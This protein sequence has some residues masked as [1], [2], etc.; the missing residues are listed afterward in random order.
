VDLLIY[1]NYQDHQGGQEKT[2]K[3]TIKLQY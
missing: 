1:Q 2:D 3:T